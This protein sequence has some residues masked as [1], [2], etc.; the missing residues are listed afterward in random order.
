MRFVSAFRD[1]PERALATLRRFPVVLIAGTLLAAVMMMDRL[2]GEGERQL[3]TALLAIIIAFDLTLVKERLGLDNVVGQLGVLVLFGALVALVYWSI[4][5]VPSR[6][7]SDASV[8]HVA[9]D[10]PMRLIAIGV[11][12]HALAAVIPFLRRPTLQGFWQYNR[13]LFLRALSS[14]LFTGILTGGLALAL[15]AL[16]ELLGIDIAGDTYENLVAFMTGIVS[17]WF[18]LAGVPASTHD[19]SPESD[20]SYPRGLKAFV[21]FVLLP[22]TAVYLIILYLYVGR[23]AIA[24]NLPEGKVSFLIFSYA[25][26]GILA[27]LLVYPLRDDDNNRWIRTF[28]RGFFLALAP[29]LVV[30]VI[31]LLRRTSDYGL[32]EPRYYGLVLA[33]W[34]A[35]IVGYFLAR[36][37]DIRFIPLSLAIGALV[38]TVGPWS[39]TAVAIRSQ[40]DRLSWVTEPTRRP[41]SEDDENAVRSIAVFLAERGAIDRGAEL[42][43]NRP[44]TVRS[45]ASLVGLFGVDPDYLTPRDDDVDRRHYSY[46]SATIVDVSGY[47]DIMELQ[48]GSNSATLHEISQTLGSVVVRWYRPGVLIVSTAGDSVSLRLDSALAAE[49]ARGP[50][51]ART[52]VSETPTIAAS[53]ASGLRARFI[54]DYLAGSVD[55]ASAIVEDVGG[56]L[57]IGYAPTHRPAE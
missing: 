40:V 36:R 2:G 15:W 33:G 6:W 12:L 9:E 53:T 18:F 19:A 43:T 22:L 37:E 44:D 51:T 17:T 42:A 30:L 48:L 7:S 3:F 38:T 45:A 5:L 11:A 41:L 14:A 27:Y 21:Q 13:Q 56:T 24:W 34:L 57:M 29:L 23:I 39:A 26:V 49:V 8:M 25:V 46:A 50:Q 28:S 31:A 52:D 1:A 55:S 32:T 54:P 20:A 35:L 47:S 4:D 10:E 16:D